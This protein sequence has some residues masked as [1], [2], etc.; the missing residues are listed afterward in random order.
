[1]ADLEKNIK[2][3][4][5]LSDLQLGVHEAI[6]SIQNFWSSVEAG[7][8]R[9]TQSFQLMTSAF[10]SQSS[11]IQVGMRDTQRFSE[12]FVQL[13]QTSQVALSTYTQDLGN[14]QKEQESAN[15]SAKR[16]AESTKVVFGLLAQ[17]APAFFGKFITETINAEKQQAQ[18]A[19]VLK[20][21]GE[22]AGWSQE[23]LNG[24]AASLSKS[25]VFST[26]EITQAQTQLLNYSNVV[27]QQFPQAMQA[28]VDMS[29]RM[30][31]SVTSSAETIG[32][33]LNSPSQGLKALTDKGVQFTDQQK[34]MV[35]QLEATGQV[36]AAQAVILDALQTSYGGAAV[37]ARDT[38]GGALDALQNSFATAMTGDSGSLQGMRESIES[39]NDT[40]SSEATREGFQTVIGAIA[41][42]IEIAIKGIS[43]LG[44]LANAASLSRKENAHKTASASFD[45]NKKKHEEAK[46]LA[47]AEPGNKRYVDEAKKYYDAMR[48][49]HATMQSI[50]ASM[51]PPTIELPTVKVE[52]PK[53]MPR[54]APSA[55][56]HS[57]GNSRR[58]SGGS[59]QDHAISGIKSRI[60]AEED[61]I[62]RLK[63]RGAAAAS[64]SE[65]D[66]LVM[67]LQKEIARTT[68]A[69]T[70]ANLQGQLVEAQRYQMIQQGRN[71]LEKQIQVQDEASKSY[72]KYIDDLKKS[73]SA[74]GEMA[75]K[76]D[77]A[78]AN[79]GKLTLPRFHVHQVMQPTGCAPL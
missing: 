57:A 20:S 43:A 30:G 32:Q 71:E 79:F 65:S 46:D 63:E 53:V 68:D 27:G 21:T 59:D 51:Q 7:S 10:Q 56:S 44:Q 76:Q 25:S 49:D 60:A 3:G 6:N 9:S 66:Q 77:T 22:T 39:L 45:W 23:R 62:D 5:D 24:M 70:K 67:K 17:G 61:L 73:A 41:G 16:W 37:A 36:G 1:M 31:T 34:E 47:E 19:A 54:Q 72:L 29:S 4:V 2:I 12:T 11:V 42:V 18:L 40:L 75:D 13:R 35:A 38:L 14:V 26:G 52:T 15:G 28:V 64:M 48:A 50:T 55:G 69:S 74:I 78:N 33:A 8:S 58:E